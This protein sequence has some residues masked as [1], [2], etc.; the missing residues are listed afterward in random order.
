MKNKYF[1]TI[2]SPIGFIKIGGNEEFVTSVSYEDGMFES[3]GVLPANILECRKQ[4]E[5]YFKGERKNFSIDLFFEGTEFQK[6]VWNELLNIPYG[7]TSTYKMIALNTFGP[8]YSRAVG[9]ANRV[10]PIAIIVPCHRIIAQNGD[11]SG[12]NGAVWR[13]R[14]LLEHEGISIK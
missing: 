3:N 14:W 8:N 2:N 10:N 9:S 11:I 5:E 12:Y 6:N 4:L 13:K 7:S 1:T